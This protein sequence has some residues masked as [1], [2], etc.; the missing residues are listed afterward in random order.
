MI[1]IPKPGAKVEPT[2]SE[3]EPQQPSI[4]QQFKAGPPPEV[5]GPSAL[6]TAS[7]TE[8]VVGTM[9]LV[10][11]LLYNTMVVYGPTG[12]RKTTQAGEFAKYIYE[13]TGKKTRL[14][15]MDG[16][17]WGP[18]QPLIN[19]G[20]IDAWRL[21]EERDP[22]VAIIFASRG[23]WPDKLVNGLR[24]SSKITVPN[25][26]GRVKALQDIGGYIVEGWSSIA[27]A[28]IRD[29]VGKGQKISED[30]VG[31]FTE[32]TEYGSE[33][34]GAPA[35]SHYGFVQNIMGD[36][37][38]NFSG[39]PLE[40]ILYTSLEGKGEDNISKQMVY[41]PEVAGKAMTASVP[42]SVGD[43]LHFEDYVKDA[44]VD[45]NNTKQKLVEVSVRVWYNSHP[46]SQTGVLWPAK[47]RVG[48]SQVERFK[49]LVGPSGYFD[50]STTSVGD[51]LRVQDETLTAATQDMIAWRAG[52]DAK[53]AL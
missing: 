42:A 22:K 11:R 30:V 32:T 14:I 8:S 9:D 27:K 10:E 21:V 15:S 33:S 3:S 19:A 48:P 6:K 52:I 41:G 13:K 40:R 26:A 46:D 36:M 37:I 12:T 34:F 44:G 28:I 49:K 18:I 38:R 31:L 47:S 50:L 35:K 45:P 25:P 39:L 43:C 5:T 29:T 16:G 24:A 4:L 7:K 1:E 51:Y 20:I 17:G 23:G 53:R 2:P